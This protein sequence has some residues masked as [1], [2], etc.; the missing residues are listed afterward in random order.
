MRVEAQ[1]R[2]ILK[3]VLDVRIAQWKDYLEAL[4]EDEHIQHPWM[5]RIEK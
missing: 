5:V 4:G 3:E 2:I 1:M